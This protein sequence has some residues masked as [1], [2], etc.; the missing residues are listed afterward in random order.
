MNLKIAAV[1]SILPP[2]K[3]IVV[4]AAF[5]LAQEIYNNNSKNR[6]WKQQ[7]LSNAAKLFWR[8]MF[9][10]IKEKKEKLWQLFL[11]PNVILLSNRGKEQLYFVD[12]LEVLI[13]FWNELKW[14]HVVL[15]H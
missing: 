13:W 3:T 4:A 15:V 9:I 1:S 5:L 8:D 11:T 6:F 7:N 2:H 10:V 14:T 12:V